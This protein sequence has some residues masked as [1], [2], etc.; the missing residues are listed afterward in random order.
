MGLEK[1][2][3]CLSLHSLHIFH[4]SGSNCKNQERFLLFLDLYNLTCEDF[5]L[6]FLQSNG[7]WSQ[8]AQSVGWTF[9]S[10]CLLVV[11]TIPRALNQSPNK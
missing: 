3:A 10:G 7:D 1:G 9:S 2:H 6:I 4:N 8:L 5:F 11:F